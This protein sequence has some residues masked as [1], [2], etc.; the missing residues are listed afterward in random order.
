M[1][2]LDDTVRLLNKILNIEILIWLIPKLSFLNFKQNS[3]REFNIKN[4][5]GDFLKITYYQS[6]I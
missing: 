1:R 3:I 6:N 4:N 2:M 5:T